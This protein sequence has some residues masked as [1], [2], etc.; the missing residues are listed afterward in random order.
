MSARDSNLESFLLLRC[1]FLRTYITFWHRLS[2]TET[3]RAIW[4]TSCV[5]DDVAGLTVYINC[6]SIVCIKFTSFLQF[7]YLHV[8]KLRN[9][10]K[11]CKTWIFQA[12]IYGYKVMVRIR[13]HMC[14]DY[15]TLL[16]ARL[17]QRCFYG[18]LHLIQAV[19]LKNM[20]DKKNVLVKTCSFLKILQ[21]SFTIFWYVAPFSKY[22]Q[23]IFFTKMSVFEKY[24]KIIKELVI[25]LLKRNNFLLKYFNVSHILF[26]KN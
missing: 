8:W 11:F 1:N 22:M 3:F 16:V 24:R 12:Q 15:V 26:E 13:P 6:I 18:I 5:E 14:I 17:G 9:M 10:I 4:G 19:H 2:I 23:Y 25:E 7:P 20:R 21:V